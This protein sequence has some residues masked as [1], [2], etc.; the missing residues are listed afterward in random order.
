VK[1][2]ISIPSVNLAYGGPAVSVVALANGLAQAGHQIGLWCPNNSVTRVEPMS[3]AESLELLTGT[4]DQAVASF[5]MPQLMH[6]NGIWWAHNHRIARY[7]ERHGL[8]RVVSTRGMLEPWAR[9]HKRGRKTV[10]WQLYQKRDLLSAAALHATS[11]QEAANVEALMPGKLVAAIGNG[12]DMPGE[13]SVAFSDGARQAGPRQALFLGRIHP[14]KG[15]PLLLRAWHL[16]APKDWRLVLAGPDEEGHQQLLEAEVARLGLAG[17]VSFT[18]PVSGE[19][20]AQLLAASHL[21]VLPSHSESFGMVVGEALAHGLPV[22]TTLN[23]PWP[24]LEQLGCGWR[25]SG[26]VEA[27]AAA[28]SD[29]TRCD[30]QRLAQMGRRG[31]DLIA[32]QYGWDKIAERFTGLYSRVLANPGA[33]VSA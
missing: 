16:A 1:I 3:G 8:P 24:Q 27:I 6:D 21:F 31:R 32:E 17:V 7:A 30:N 23:V 29:A 10:A 33:P 9:R 13:D 19:A 5:G 25:V 28:L 18:G 12:L 15:L 14:V 11:D 20:K 4:F 2:F 22:L 26:T